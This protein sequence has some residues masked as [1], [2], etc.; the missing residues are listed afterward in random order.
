MALFQ[1]VSWGCSQG[2]VIWRL[3]WRWWFCFQDGSHGVGQ[4]G[5]DLLSSPR[6]GF[7]GLF[8]FP[9]AWAAH[10]PWSKWPERSVSHDAASEVTHCH[11][12]GSSGSHVSVLFI[13]GDCVQGH[14]AKRQESLG[15]NW[16]H[17]WIEWMWSPPSKTFLTQSVS[18]DR[19]QIVR[20]ITV[21]LWLRYFPMI[22]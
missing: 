3:D 19:L 7:C 2:R 15:A 10:L 5:G 14:D 9:H 4:P 22:S 21:Y 11:L 16:I 1:G 17:W 8:E 20:V 12:A 18:P 6:V 13:A